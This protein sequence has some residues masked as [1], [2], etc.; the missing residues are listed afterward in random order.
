MSTQTAI[1]S[2]TV[3]LLLVLSAL[4]FGCSDDS[5][6]SGSAGSAPQERP[7]GVESLSAEIISPAKSQVYIV[8]G[9]SVHFEGSISGGVAPFEYDWD[10]NNDA[11]D[12]AVKDPGDIFFFE[13]GTYTVSFAVTDAD[14]VRD[15][16]SIVVVVVALP[17]VPDP[18]EASIISPS[19]STIIVAGES[20]SFQALVSGGVPPYRYSWNFGDGA[21]NVTELNPRN[22]RFDIPGAYSVLFTA[23]DSG[24]ATADSEELQI[25]VNEAPEVITEP[26]FLFKA[27]GT[28][29]AGIKNTLARKIDGTLWVWGDNW[30][31]QIGNDTF[32]N[33]IIP[34]QVGYDSNWKIVAVS[35]YHCIAMKFDGSLWA[36]GRNFYN[37]VGDT[38]I[39]VCNH[40][41]RFGNDT[42][43]RFITTGEHFSVALKTNG[44]LWAWGYND[45]GQLGIGNM[46]KA[47]HPVQVGSDADWSYIAAGK[48]HV[49]AVKN[50]GTLW[51]WGENRYGQLGNGSENESMIPIQIGFD[52]DWDFV[53]AGYYHSIGHKKNGTIWTWGY[54]GSGQLGSLIVPGSNVPIQVGL[55]ND[56]GMIAAGGLHTL[57]IKTD[58]SLWTWGDNQY[59]QLGVQ[60]ASRNFYTP[61]QV[62][63]DNQWD[64]V[65]GGGRHSMARK[66]DGTLWTW[67]SNA[68]G[69][70]GIGSDEDTHDPTVVYN[71]SASII[72]PKGNVIVEAGQPVDFK[73]AGSGFYPPFRYLWDFQ[74]AAASITSEEAGNVLFKDGGTYRATFTV[75]DDKGMDTSRFIVVTVLSKLPDPPKVSIT[76]PINDTTITAGGK[77]TFK[78]QVDGGLAPFSYMWDFGGGATTA[79]GSVNPRDVL[80]STPGSYSV[81]LYVT[82]GAGREVASEPIVIR[83]DSPW[84]VE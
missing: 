65:A 17:E 80:F 19:G 25:T 22:I 20:I 24:G 43:W 16:S 48:S 29:S 18:L 53:D 31:G 37:Q 73:G 4:F 58:G 38:S 78:G 77:L 74:G 45:S 3:I 40:P 67:G 35:E 32:E 36:W 71:L 61:V 15:Q 27:Y 33:S 83:V 66:K 2:R 41:V 82:D 7:A 51:A 14:G 28:I 75:T 26:D 44:T 84:L 8:E 47:D 54:N 68:Y 63:N 11:E 23:Y 5:D 81:T 62:G 79:K 12:L 52:E 64:A 59:G 46:K 34:F 60:L 69:Q 10:F 49:V 57:A 39:E 6:D 9:Q 13:A 21:N 76:S 56:W 70:L 30:S 1:L 72:Y 50:D 42:D 55:E